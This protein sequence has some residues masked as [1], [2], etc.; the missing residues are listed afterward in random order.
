[1]DLGESGVV[2]KAMSGKRFTEFTATCP[3]CSAVSLFWPTSEGRTSLVYRPNGM[4]WN[5]GAAEIVVALFVCASCDKVVVIRSDGSVGKL[6]PNWGA[7]FGHVSSGLRMLDP[8]GLGRPE[9][10]AIVP[11]D[12]RRDYMEA[13]SIWHL[14]PKS[15]AALLRRI[16]DGMLRE[17]LDK[18]GTLY[19]MIESLKPPKIPDYVWNGLHDLRDFGNWA[20]HPKWT[21]IGMIVDVEVDEVSDCFDVIDVMFDHWYVAPQREL[22]RRAKVDARKR[23]GLNKRPQ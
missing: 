20:A 7:E 1:M 10:D 8:G 3:R 13:V 18:S 2:A 6:S 4:G 5:D 9:P 12:W 21:D 19:Q 11:E 16:V 14:S 23:A 17:K 15:A 22:A